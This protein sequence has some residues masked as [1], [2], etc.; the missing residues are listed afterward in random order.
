MFTGNLFEIFFSYT[1]K[2]IYCLKQNKS[3]LDFQGV[4]KKFVQIF[5]NYWISYRQE[6]K[7]GFG[8]FVER[9][10]CCFPIWCTSIFI[11]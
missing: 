5:F 3:R 11:P 1:K 8:K 7:S 10:N 4:S 6:A 2:C 9:F